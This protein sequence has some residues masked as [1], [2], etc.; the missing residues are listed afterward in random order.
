MPVLR[1]NTKEIL[2]SLQNEAKS[3]LKTNDLENDPILKATG[4]EDKLK[5][6]HKEYINTIDNYY[7][8][9]DNIHLYNGFIFLLRLRGKEFNDGLEDVIKSIVDSGHFKGLDD[10]K[11]EEYK[12]NFNAL[13]A[14]LSESFAEQVKQQ[15]AHIRE[16]YYQK[17]RQ[18][19]SASSA[20]FQPGDVTIQKG[21]VPMGAETY[22]SVSKRPRLADLFL[23]YDP[24]R[25]T[26]IMDDGNEVQFNPMDPDACREVILKIMP[27]RLAKLGATTLELELGAGDVMKQ[28]AYTV[29]GVHNNPHLRMAGM[30][31][32]ILGNSGG[33]DYPGKHFGGMAYAGTPIDAFKTIV[34]PNMGNYKEPDFTLE[35]LARLKI[36][37]DNAYKELEKDL[38][39]GTKM[40]QQ[41]FVKRIQST[42]PE[43]LRRSYDSLS[44]AVP[45]YDLKV[46]GMILNS[47]EKEILEVVKKL[48][49]NVDDMHGAIE[50]LMLE[51][52]KALGTEPPA[53]RHK[54]R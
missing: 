17:A 10:A 11:Q 22:A 40:S 1:I 32:L 5:E 26:W 8:D 51:H 27:E 41:E 31:C 45:P 2:S 24:N 13:Q 12:R 39:S 6:F 53:N 9:Q 50:G 14:S 28:A 4:F 47:K 35:E 34:T 19:A 15:T 44:G 30:F 37:F 23:F 52:K 21:E 25:K 29:Q 54:V 7:G 48:R 42:I 49:S 46:K 38:E 33:M 16:I 3:I 36:Q 20:R 43:D 18:Q